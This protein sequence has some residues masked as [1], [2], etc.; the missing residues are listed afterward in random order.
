MDLQVGATI[1]A[2]SSH[3]WSSDTEKSLDL[4]YYIMEASKRSS[5]C[6]D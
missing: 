6:D 1:A 3:D 4:V 5:C 2:I